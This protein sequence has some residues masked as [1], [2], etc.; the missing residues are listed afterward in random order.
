MTDRCAV[1][2]A[3]VILPTAYIAK[4]GLNYY[5]LP[6]R[7][8]G[9]RYIQLNITNISAEIEIIYAGIVTWDLPLPPESDFD[10]AD[11]GIMKLRRVAIDT[12]KLCMHDQL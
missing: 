1:K 7:R 6:F 5:Q 12:M 3:T 8:M 2:S 4:A 9:G 11:P 10:C